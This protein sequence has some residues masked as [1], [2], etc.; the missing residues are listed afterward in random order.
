MYCCT[1]AHGSLT[2]FQAFVEALF[3]AGVDI[4]QF[5]DKTMEARTAWPYI[6]ALVEAAER[7]DAL[8]CVNDRADLAV[9][10][11][12]DVVH[13]GQDDLTPAQVRQVVGGAMLIGRSTHAIAESLEADADA[14]VDY[15]AVGPV[16]PNTDETWA[17]RAGTRVS[18][19]GGRSKS[20]KAVVRHRRHRWCSCVGSVRS[21]CSSNR[22]RKGAHRNF[23]AEGSD[24]WAVVCV[25][26]VHRLVD[27]DST[28]RSLERD[29]DNAIAIF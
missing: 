16:C 2:D 6:L 7:H 5:R 18:A 9:L 10:A 25:T 27:A 15:F 20:A 12:A 26:K 3:S 8:S 28:M 24:D 29:S 14:D 21:W 1:D 22:R 17:T 23:V 19:R 4:I 13:V 11:N